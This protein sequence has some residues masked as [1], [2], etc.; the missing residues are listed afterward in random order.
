LSR[1]EADGSA[2]SDDKLNLLDALKDWKIWVAALAYLGAEEN[3]SSTVSFQP[4]VLNG[5]GFTAS[6]AQV[7]SIPVY[8][9][10]WVVSMTCAVLAERLRKRY[11][12]AMFGMLLTTIGLAIEIAQP[13]AAGVRYLGM[14]FVTAGPYVT[15]PVTLVWLAINLGT[16]YKRT[17][18]IGLLVSLGNSGNLISSNVFLTRETPTFHTGFSV[19]MGLNIMSGIMLTLLFFGL[20]KENKRLEGREGGGAV[21]FRYST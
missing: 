7:H 10:A 17:V 3:A 1:L 19:G 14:F 2:I 6:S 9:V 20:R 18:G 5:L 13:K 12:F 21:G 8:V 11:V 16:G 4:T 15:M